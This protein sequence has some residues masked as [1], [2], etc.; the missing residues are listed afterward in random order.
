MSNIR[1]TFAVII[2]DIQNDFKKIILP[3]FVKSITRLASYCKI[4][5]IPVFWIKSHYGD[6]SIDE[7]E[8]I[9]ETKD[10]KTIDCKV[11]ILDIQYV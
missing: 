1:D 11:V 5:K 10:K 8:K 6:F 4:K 3:D 2:I 7:I 9:K